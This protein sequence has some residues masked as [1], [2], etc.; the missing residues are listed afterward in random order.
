MKTRYVV[1]LLLITLTLVAWNGLRDS[2]LPESVAGALPPQLPTVTATRTP[3]PGWWRDVSFATPTLKKLPGLPNPQFGNG[4]GGQAP[5]TKVA[6][7]PISCPT[8]GVKIS[9]IR[10]AAG[11]WW[12]IFG[13]ASIPNLWYWKAETSADGQQWASLYQA[14]TTVTDGL[15]LRLNL[16]TVP[17]GARQMRLTAVDRTGNY[18]EPCVVKISSDP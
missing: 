7:Q 6:F 4:V 17:A 8:A 2:K 3:A 9:D 14:E 15:L 13:S 16:T 10:T 1:P 5:G 11:P 12:H 18:P